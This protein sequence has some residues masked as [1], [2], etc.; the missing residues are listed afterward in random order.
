MQVCRLTVGWPRYRCSSG[1][2]RPAA[3]PGAG[4]YDRP[5][6]GCRVGVGPAGAGRQGRGHRLREQDHHQ[7]TAHPVWA[8]QQAGRVAGVAGRAGALGVPAGDAYW[9]S[10]VGR[11]GRKLQRPTRLLR[12]RPTLISSYGQTSWPVGSAVPA[13][14][15]L[16]D[17][18]DPRSAASVGTPSSSGSAG[19]PV[20]SG[21]SSLPVDLSCG[22]ADD[23]P[24]PGPSA[25][26]YIP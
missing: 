12:Q 11:C 16:I 22:W 24:G 18:W 7:T 21:S 8:V 20:G 3:G 1:W 4:G 6:V 25:S 10:L 17:S 23:R 9:R 15:R 14:D 19:T 2:S 5:A 26:A 13:G